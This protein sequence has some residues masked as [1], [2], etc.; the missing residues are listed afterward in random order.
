MPN[1]RIPGER[2]ALADTKTGRMDRAWYRFLNDLFNLTGAGQTVSNLVTLTDEVDGL[3][4]LPPVAPPVG[5]M[6]VG[7]VTAV[8]NFPSTAANSSSV[9]TV[10]V[11]GAVDG[12]FVKLAAPNASVPANGHF[13]AWVSAANTVSVR[14]VNN[15][16]AAID[17]TSGTF[18]VVVE[19]Y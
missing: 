10:T 16:V 3:L 18:R 9:L 2:V 1:S 15:T 5:P 11:P 19:R 13:Y 17:P 7:N 4:V 14:F 6:I 8:L 12:D